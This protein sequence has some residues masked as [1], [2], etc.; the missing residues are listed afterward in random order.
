LVDYVGGNVSTDRTL[1]IWS[2]HKTGIRQIP[3]N[4][5]YVLAKDE[6]EHKHYYTSRIK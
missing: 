3:T 2:H 5:A 1:V 4:D 6:L